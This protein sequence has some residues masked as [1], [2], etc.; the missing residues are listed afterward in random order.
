MDYDEF[1]NR[2]IKVQQA[3]KGFRAGMDA[4]FLAAAVSDVKVGQDVLE[5]GCATGVALFCLHHRLRVKA[6]YV[7]IDVQED[8]VKMARNGN[9]LNKLEDKV[10]FIV[11]D[12]FN[13]SDDFKQLKFDHILTNPPFYEKG[14]LTRSDNEQRVKSFEEK[15]DLKEWIEACRKK[16]KPKGEFTIIH[17][18]ERLPDIMAAMNRYF[19][20]IEVFPLFTK[21]GE[22]AKRVIVKGKIDHK[23]GAKLYPGMVLRDKHNESTKEENEILREGKGLVFS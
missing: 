18:A 21:Q 3:E 14:S 10:H 12:I 9:D 17:Q 11:E 13:P 2:R 1:L 15:H 8:L 19:G 22:V 20:R 5:V 7:G 16:L 6:N 4:V 23:G